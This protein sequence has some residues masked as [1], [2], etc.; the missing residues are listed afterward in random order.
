MAE[1]EDYIQADRPSIKD[2]KS[3]YRPT[4]RTFYFI[5]LF[6]LISIILSS[7]DIPLGQM[8]SGQAFSMNLGFPMTFISFTPGILMPIKIVGLIVDLLVFFIISYALDLVISMLSLS[9]RRAMPEERKN[10]P[11]LYKK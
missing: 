8:M 6:F 9:A 3:P 5:G 1:K 11:R 2:I 7:F 4:S 10:L